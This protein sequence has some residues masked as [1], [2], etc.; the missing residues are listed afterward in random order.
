[1]AR[2]RQSRPD[3]DLGVEL[4][5][6]ETLKV[7]PSLLESK[8]RGLTPPLC[9]EKCLRLY[10]H[11]PPVGQVRYRENVARIGQSR[12]DSGLV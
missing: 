9:V 3:F 5:V 4:T 8:K 7:V 12:P 1:M 10:N 6:L 11:P 2:V